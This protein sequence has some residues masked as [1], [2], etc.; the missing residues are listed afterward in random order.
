MSDSR[1][2]GLVMRLGVTDDF[3]AAISPCV[4]A[5]SEEAASWVQERRQSVVGGCSMR[6]LDQIGIDLDVHRERRSPQMD[7]P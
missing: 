4:R 3:S 7:A 5:R 2:A 6:V 1:W